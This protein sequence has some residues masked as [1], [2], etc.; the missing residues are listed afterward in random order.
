MPVMNP[1]W[2]PLRRYRLRIHRRC[3]SKLS[4]TAVP[5]TFA[6][7]SCES[8][9]VSASPIPTVNPPLMIHPGPTFAEIPLMPLEPPVLTRTTYFFSS[10]TPRPRR[11]IRPFTVPLSGLYTGFF[12]FSVIATSSF[13]DCR[14]SRSLC[15]NH[16]LVPR[17]PYLTNYM[18]HNLTPH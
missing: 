10:S 12:R 16:S 4:I 1:C 5:S 13:P 3:R 8:L 15:E 6:D 11:R 18:F 7:A 2:Y 14:S 17:S 9:V